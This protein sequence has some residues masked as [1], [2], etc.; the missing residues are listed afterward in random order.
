VR[1][2]LARFPQD[3]QDDRGAIAQRVERSGPSGE[4]AGP[5][6]RLPVQP[7]MIGRQV[8]FAGAARDAGALL[9]RHQPVV[10]AQVLSDL[11]GH[12]EQRRRRLLDVAQ[13]ARQRL[14]RDLW[15]FLNDSSTCFWRSSSCSRSDF[16]SARLDT[17]MISNSVSSAM[18]WSCER[19]CL[20]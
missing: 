5:L 13:H 11:A 18:W 14:F 20:R 15:L 17:S 12:G 10:L 9:D 3:A 1:L 8:E 2:R 7:V 6:L 4:L 16:K 19:C